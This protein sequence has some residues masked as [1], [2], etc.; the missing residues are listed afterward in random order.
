[1]EDSIILE[2]TVGREISYEGIG[3]HT[4][5][6]IH[7]TIHPAPPLT[8]IVFRRSKGFFNGTV[9]ASYKNISRAVLATT[10]GFNGTGVSTV[11]HL[12]AA[13]MG[14]G[15]DN[16]IVEVDGPEIPIADGSSI[17]Y[18]KLILQAGIVPQ[19]SYRRF[20]IIRSTVRITEGDAYLIAS[21]SHNQSLIIDYSIDFPHPLIGFQ[22]INWQFDSRKFVR[23]IAPA[24][25][26]GFLEDVTILRAK[27]LAL[28]G[29]L[30]N[31]LV[32]DKVSLLNPEGFRFRDECVRHKVLDL[33]GDIMLLGRPVI[34]H[35]IV[36]K[37]GHRLHHKLLQKLPSVLREVSWENVKTTVQSFA[38]PLRDDF[39]NLGVEF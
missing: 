14:C 13:L 9:R 25:T 27:G 38:P 22:S 37:G 1:M 26:F 39:Y 31:A 35:F 8:G 36:H 5:K 16:A 2:H 34:G 17:T 19:E 32:F 30:D 11:E 3:L 29:S 23:E 6:K 10:I 33:L 28:G 20:F 15:I 7:V 4:G 12:L 21:P 18:V 24:R